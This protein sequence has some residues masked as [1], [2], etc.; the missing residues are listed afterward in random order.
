[1]TDST[2][3][4]RRMAALLDGRLDADARQQLLGELAASDEALDAYADAAAVLAE[5]ER[6]GGVA[7]AAGPSAA[8]RGLPDVP[9]QELSGRTV[10][11]PVVSIE[12]ARA[13][14]P[15]RRTPRWMALAA[16][17]AV[18]VAVPALWWRTHPAAD[19]AGPPLATPAD[20]IVGAPAPNGPPSYVALL[21]PEARGAG[22]PPAWDGTP[23]RTTRGAG[24]PLTPEARAVRVGARL[25][26]LELAAAARDTASVRAVA[27]E[28]AALLDE[29]P[30]GAGAA[31]GYRALGTSAAAD[32]AALAR[33]RR[34]AA[35]VAGEE[36]VALG[37]WIEAARVAA[38]RRDA[39]FFRTAESRAA[40]GRARGS[41]AGRAL[42][43]DVMPRLE[44]AL[45]GGGDPAWA[46]TQRGLS[47]L[48]TALGG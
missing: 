44:R 17:I 48:L 22:L 23:W 3:D 12:A 35:L 16:G 8:G 33:T 19:P 2:P 5:L 45:D 30:G 26:D 24:D 36:F 15:V 6:A 46:D 34:D 39:G 37:M 29:V 43:P 28:V 27:A 11:T 21:A 20:A 40:L 1:M 13:R 32:G 14:R 4:A 42:A 25:T 41:V 10:P 18:T 38:A 47:A 7:P 31:A 9:A